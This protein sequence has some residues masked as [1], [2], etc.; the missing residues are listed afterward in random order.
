MTDATVQTTTPTQST[1]PPSSTTG[2]P[3]PSA[4]APKAT[5][6]SDGGDS[7]PNGAEAGKT[8]GQGHNSGGHF[9]A[10]GDW[11]SGFVEGLDDA[12]RETW[13]KLSSRYTSPAEMAKAHVNLVQTMDKR[14]AI[15]GPDAK[16]EE[17]DAVFQKLGMPEKPDDYKFNLDQIT[18]W[19][20]ARK[21]QIKGL[22][23]LFRKARATQTQVDEFVAQQAEID[24]VQQEAF[25]AQANTIAQQRRKQLETEWRGEDFKRNKSF[26]K[27]T[28]ETYAGADTD[29]I[30]GLRLAD[31]TFA[32]DH[33][34]F[35]RMFA[36]IGAERAEDDRDPSA[37]NG[38]MRDSAKA[39]IEQIEREALDKG[40][41]PTHP[42]W[43]HARLDALYKKV[44]GSRNLHTA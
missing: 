43:P 1:P 44:A 4:A 36:K 18:H 28:V 6:L 42:N 33:P 27:A 31:G 13:G 9:D 35:A 34:A 41:S 30:A 39:Q 40:W 8:G 15:P 2:A 5:M 14:I 37:F 3:P 21:E 22:A 20:P 38:G 19:D 26:V 23:P 32:V 29:E 16:P 24:R 7:A 17:V 12:T 10:N 11:R 25:E